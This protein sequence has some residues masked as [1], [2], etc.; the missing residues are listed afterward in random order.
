VTKKVKT[1]ADYAPGDKVKIR[2]KG[3]QVFTIVE[4][5]HYRT[6]DGWYMLDAE[7]R[8]RCFP[9]SLIV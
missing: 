8:H 9:T 5:Y 6:I 3:R 1:H 4:D 2:G 7:Q